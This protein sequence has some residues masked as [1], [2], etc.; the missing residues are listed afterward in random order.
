MLATGQYLKCGRVCKKLWMPLP[1]WTIGDY[2]EGRTGGAWEALPRVEMGRSR[3][4]CAKCWGMRFDPLT[5]YPDEAWNR[6]VSVVSGG[7]LYGHEVLMPREWLHAL[8]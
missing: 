7:L 4:A 2:L 3:F 1:A 6:F 8:Y 5:T